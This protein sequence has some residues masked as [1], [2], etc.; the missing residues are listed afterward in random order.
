MKI[1]QHIPDFV[2]TYGFPPKES[3]FSDV[4]SFYEIDFVKDWSNNVEKHDHF[5]LD[6]A[7]GCFYIL[8]VNKDK[9]WWWVVGKVINPDKEFINSFTSWKMP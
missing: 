6:N 4:R 9:T 1:I 5:E 2:E 3:T 7:N 8:S